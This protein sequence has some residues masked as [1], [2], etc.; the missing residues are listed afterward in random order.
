VGLDGV[1][2]GVLLLMNDGLW[3]S[4]IGEEREGLS[5]AH[6]SVARGPYRPGCLAADG[7]PPVSAVENL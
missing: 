5:G 2:V 6:D 7:W 1:A 3:M 4:W